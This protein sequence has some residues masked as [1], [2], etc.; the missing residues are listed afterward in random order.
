M[1]Q[2]DSES[3]AKAI[4]SAVAESN[5]PP[6]HNNIFAL[7]ATRDGIKAV[8]AVKINNTWNINSMISTNYHGELEAGI[9]LKGSWK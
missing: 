2:F 9:L 7:A 8:I 4:A 1:T 3:L 6:G 5:I